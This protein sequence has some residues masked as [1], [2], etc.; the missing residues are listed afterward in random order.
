MSVFESDFG[1]GSGSGSPHTDDGSAR[2]PGLR[3]HPTRPGREQIDVA[4]RQGPHS[5]A[6]NEKG[7]PPHSDGY[8]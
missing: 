7:C 8:G 6:H 3:G 5:D 4:S 1:S 2:M